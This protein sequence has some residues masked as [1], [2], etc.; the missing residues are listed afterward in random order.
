[1]LDGENA[2]SPE[3]GEENTLSR[4]R[5]VQ[6]S[7]V[8][9][10]SLGLG[11]WLYEQAVPAAKADGGH[12][13]ALF[14][15]TEF[16]D[17]LYNGSLA[18]NG[19]IWIMEAQSPPYG[20]YTTF[21]FWG[22][23]QWAA[24]HGDGTIK[25]NYR[26]YLNGDPNQPNAP[27][28]DWHADLI[29]QA[30]VDF[31]V[32]DFTNGANDFSPGGP[33]YVSATKAL[34]N[35]YQQRAQ[36]GSPI[37][38]VVFFVKDA[39]TLQTV[40]NTYFNAYPGN[41]FFNY[42]GKKLV[43]VAQPNTALSQ[44]DSGQPAVPTDGIFGNYTTRHCW[45][46]DTSGTC[47]QFK[48]AADTPPPPFYYNGQ[49]EQM[50]APVATQASYMTTDGVN[51]APG[52]IGRQNGSYFIK[53]MDAAKNA[54]VT[55]VFIH[56]WNEWA[57]GNWGQNQP[58][59]VDQW[60]T[61]YSSDIEPMDGGHGSQYY[62]LM[63]QKIAEF[64]GTGSPSSFPAPNTYYKIS[65][66]NSGE[67]LAVSGM[68]QD[69]GAQVTQ[70]N[71]NGTPDHNWKFDDIGG[72]YYHIVNQNSGKVLAV[73]NMSHDD[74]AQ[75]TQWEDNGTADHNWQL[76]DIGGGYY[77]IVNQNSGKLIAVSGMSQADGAYVTQWED[78]GTPDHNWH[79]T[80]A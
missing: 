49:P 16:G 44:G 4:R 55:F 60:L 11:T 52:A 66:Q 26:F 32:L 22:K 53:Y 67:V 65:N 28:L 51:P 37:P 13:V 27:L 23:P 68:S 64:K 42:L 79:L 70:W 6:G 19:D 15:F 9:G 38:Q 12:Y 61:E 10:A 35:R 73:S 33:T 50:C 40:E 29:T 80:P 25:N 45:G 24:T 63:K 5:F 7:L 17:T 62:D 30:G 3:K 36:A 78:N 46:L 18:P 43:L 41:L 48:V 76:V 77:H 59:F 1:M 71:D 58:T 57:A 74:G 8:L 34:L 69:D 75:V 39:E 14:Y 20:P 72:G 54:G 21:N 2:H 56:S 47:W 31:I